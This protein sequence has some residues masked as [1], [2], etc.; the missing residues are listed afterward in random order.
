MN[1]IDMYLIDV[2]F[3]TGG[4]EFTSLEQSKTL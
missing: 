3:V 4:A 2:G 1:V